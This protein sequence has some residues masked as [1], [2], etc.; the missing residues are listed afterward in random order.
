MT[1]YQ[2]PVQTAQYPGYGY[3][4]VLQPEMQYYDQRMAAAYG[5]SDQMTGRM[6]VMNNSMYSSGVQMNFS[7]S[8]NNSTISSQVA[9]RQSRPE[10]KFFGDLVSMAK[11]KQPSK[12]TAGEVGNSV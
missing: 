8:S 4:A 3:A 2:L 9:I 5:M 11:K 10:D 12:P 1:Q 6:H 7:G